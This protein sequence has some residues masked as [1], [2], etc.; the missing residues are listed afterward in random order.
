M[1]KLIL[2]IIGGA[3]ALIVLGAIALISL[4]WP[5]RP[6]PVDTAAIRAQA[7]GYQ[8][9]ISRDAWGVPHIEAARN[10]DAAFALGYAHAEDD[11]ATIQSVAL[12]TR[13]TLAA[14]EGPK[15]APT[16]YLV[17]MMRVWEDIDARYETDLPADVRAVLEAYATGVN[18]YAV[19]HP[20]AVAPGLL[21]MT[22]RDVAAGFVFKTPFFYGLDRVLRDLLAPPEKTPPPPKG[23]NG[24]A[25]APSRSTDGA[26]RLLVNS[27]QPYTGPVAWYEAVI[28]TG[29]GW[30]VAGGFF[31]GSPFML[32]GHNA[33]LGWANTVNAPDL[34]DIYRL[35]IDP[36]DP[37][38]YKLDGAY[39]PFERRDA[40]LRVKLF[41][42]FFWTVTRPMLWSKHGMAF[43]TPRGVFAVRY[44]GQRDIRGALQYWRLNLATNAEEWRAAMKLQALPSINYI[45]ADRT[46]LIG[47]VY[48]GLFPE[49]AAGIDWSGVLPGD[50][51]DLIWSSYLP[52]ERTP[53]IWA[54]KSG[55][56]FN[57]NNTPFAATDAADQL[58][59][60]A[61]PAFMGLQRNMTNRAYRAQETFGGDAAINAEEFRAYKYDIAFSPRARQRGLVQALIAQTFSEPDLVAGQAILRAWDGRTD[62]ANRGAALA[63]LS[64]ARIARAEEDGETPPDLAAS[65]RQAVAHLKKH[66]G[67]LDPEWGQVMRFRR[68]AFDSAIDG[69]PD[70]LRAVYGEPQKDGTL[71]AIAGDTLIMFVTWDK[72]GAL[73]SQSI[74][75][76]GSATLDSHSAHYA[77]QAKLFAVMETKPVL[78]TRAQRAGRMRETYR[79]GERG[80]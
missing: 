32:H 39:A 26:T 63:L 18:L 67:R 25:V 12:A 35:D 56:V 11:F 46:G 69:G 66:F 14:V 65:Y 73:A 9:T 33:D 77:D 17:G 64:V 4:D 62:R 24:I 52:F 75:Q 28:E 1:R 41:G 10:P 50:R 31:P 40:R 79:P 58:A 34:I 2:R 76:F 45:Y 29:E 22:G 78:F 54:P 6:G 37:T 74:H 47:Y 57:A 48:N 5:N 44:A 80:R 72:D 15:A 19:E 20:D 23:S 16:D 36:K 68:G 55:W 38:R 8:A 60:D 7:A 51:S 42:P 30:H 71:T 59:P 49:R 27:H 3:A 21:P 61:F 43:E 70:T 13:G 53:Q